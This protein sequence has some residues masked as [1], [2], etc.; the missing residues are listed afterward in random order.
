LR[1]IV[2]RVHADDQDARGGR[3]AVERTAD[4]LDP[5]RRGGRSRDGRGLRESVWRG[6]GDQRRGGER[7]EANSRHGGN[8]SPDLLSR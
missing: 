4:L 6:G 1:E 7:A 5:A 3:E 2:I 8:L